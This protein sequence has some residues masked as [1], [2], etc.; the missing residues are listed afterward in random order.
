[1]TYLGVADGIL[2]FEILDISEGPRSSVI[3][4]SVGFYGTD[5]Q[6]GVTAR[7]GHISLLQQFQI[8]I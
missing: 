6:N 2:G 7:L 8:Y 1:M 4:P 5:P 3:L